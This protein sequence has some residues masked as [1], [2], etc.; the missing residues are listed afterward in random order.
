[1]SWNKSIGTKER[2]D[3]GGGCGCRIT[4]DWLSSCF[5]ATN[6]PE[7]AAKLLPRS[8]KSFIIGPARAKKP[9]SNKL[10]CWEHAPI[11]LDKA[12]E[13]LRSI[14]RVAFSLISVFTKRSCHDSQRVLRYQMIFKCRL[15]STSGVNDRVTASQFGHNLVYWLEGQ[16]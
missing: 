10:S 5:H 14:A 16:H 8:V 1:M 9:V 13:I 6:P 2:R 7:K 4:C 3:G 11:K 15:T 12:N